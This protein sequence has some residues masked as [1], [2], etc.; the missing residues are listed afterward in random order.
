MTFTCHLTRAA[1]IYPS[2]DHYPSRDDYPSR[3]REGAVMPAT[4]SR[5]R[6]GLG[7]LLTRAAR[8][9]VSEPR[10]SGSG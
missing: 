1:T 7:R 10:P 9:D 5:A 4:Y 6:L 2:R 3:D 8:F